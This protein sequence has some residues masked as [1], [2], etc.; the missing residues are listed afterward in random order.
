MNNV[1]LYQA[2]AGEGIDQYAS[3]DGLMTEGEKAEIV[4][5]L[6]A[7]VKWEAHK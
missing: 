5:A 7:I 1:V 2:D 3:G 6:E 4:T